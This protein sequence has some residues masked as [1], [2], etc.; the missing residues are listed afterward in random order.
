MGRGEGA[1]EEG[2][3]SLMMLGGVGVDEGVEE[4]AE[5]GVEES[6]EDGMDVEAKR[7]DK[8]EYASMALLST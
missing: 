1:V 2:T 7:S 5:E 3:A 4:G 6:V 8:A